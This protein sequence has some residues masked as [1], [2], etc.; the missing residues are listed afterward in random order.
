[1]IHLAHKETHGKKPLDST[2]ATGKTRAFQKGLFHGRF[3]S[4]HYWPHLL[5]YIMFVAFL[6]LPL[7]A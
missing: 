7:S 5:Y 1:M 4:R 2:N 6:F 3:L